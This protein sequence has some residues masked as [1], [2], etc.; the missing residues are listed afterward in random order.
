M[1]HGGKV[2]LNGQPVVIDRIL[3][4]AIGLNQAIVLQQ[5]HYWL[6]VNRR[7]GRNY[8]DGSYWTYSTMEE[9]WKRD[10][11][12]LWSYDTLCR[13]FSRLED[14]GLL[15]VGNYN[16]IRYD[17][18]KWYTIDY[19]RLEA[20]I[21]RHSPPLPVPKVTDVSTRRQSGKV[22]FDEYPI[23]VSRQLVQLVGLKHA[24]ILQQIHYWIEHNRRANRNL[25]DGKYWTHNTLDDWWEKEFSILGSK[26]TVRR[27]FKSLE[28]D[29]L[30]LVANYNPTKFDHTR[31]YTINYNRLEYLLGICSQNDHIEM[32]DLPDSER[33][34]CRDASLDFA[35][36]DSPQDDQADVTT[37]P[38]TIPDTTHEI[39][40]ATQPIGERPSSPPVGLG[41]DVSI[42]FGETQNMPSPIP[43]PF[44]RVFREQGFQTYVRIMERVLSRPFTPEEMLVAARE[45]FY[46]RV[47]EQGVSDIQFVEYVAILENTV[48]RRLNKAEREHVKRLWQTYDADML[49]KAERELYQQQQ[50][51][52]ITNPI[53]Y[54]E[55]ILTN[56]MTRGVVITNP[57]RRLPDKG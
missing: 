32:I 19:E 29:G 47:F 20:V 40:N 4:R 49:V 16:Q 48:R 51:Q 10:F 37:L 43:V 31:W 50:V 38:V 1:S 53:G 45:W 25:H 11:R 52:S 13:I 26:P 21:E 35:H 41:M 3:A 34:S 12:H 57:N 24:I 56:W 5:I 44:E 14:A 42:D 39:T 23:V 27:L 30:L 8:H 54:L 2:L 46:T 18:T 6:E 55:G 36:F 33:S 22:L 28:N 7:A 15:L 17:R 9:W